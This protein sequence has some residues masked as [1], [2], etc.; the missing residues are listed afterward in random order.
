MPPVIIYE[1]DEKAIRL[2]LT[3]RGGG[4][5]GGALKCKK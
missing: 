4:G 2:L 5:G 3:S 1:I